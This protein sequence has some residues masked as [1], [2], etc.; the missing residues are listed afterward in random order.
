MLK[1]RFGATE[2]W[3]FGSLCTGDVHG[4]S[5]VDLA[6]RGL[7]PADHMRAWAA[8]DRFD[9]AVVDLVLLEEAPPSLVERI[10]AEGVP[11]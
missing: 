2:V 11:L 9:D 3:L 5:D 1:E 10:I 6:V 8:V 7:S 4:G